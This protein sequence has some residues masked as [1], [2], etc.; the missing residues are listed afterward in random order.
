MRM[1]IIKMCFKYSKLTLRKDDMNI[2]H[3][4]KNDY[5]LKSARFY[6]L[7][8]FRLSMNRVHLKLRKLFLFKVSKRNINRHQLLSAIAPEVM[9][10]EINAEIIQTLLEQRII[11]AADVRCLDE[12]S[13]QCLKKLC[14]NT[15]LFIPA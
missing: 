5:P 11:C 4:L 8:S 6:P 9:S 12:S 14:L 3:A 2:G 1:I 15:C 7:V 13:K 10:L